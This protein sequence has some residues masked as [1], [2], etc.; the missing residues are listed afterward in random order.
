MR[1]AL[2]PLCRVACIYSHYIL[3]YMYLLVLLLILLNIR[4]LKYD[5]FLYD[6]EIGSMWRLQNDQRRRHIVSRHQYQAYTRYL[7]YGLPEKHR[8]GGFF[9]RR[10]RVSNP[11]S[12][13]GEDQ[14]KPRQFNQPD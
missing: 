13:K 9:R 14:R 11:E 12:G 3:F 10:Q 2:N 5:Y 4:G 1:S 8:R 7:K 6:I